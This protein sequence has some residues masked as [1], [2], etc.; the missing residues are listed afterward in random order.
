MWGQ[1]DT[2]KCAIQ[3]S[4]KI[5]GISRK[6]FLGIVN[7]IDYLTHRTNWYTVQMSV[8]ASLLYRGYHI[9]CVKSFYERADVVDR[10]DLGAPLVVRVP[11][12]PVK[13]N[14][15]PLG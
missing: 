5:C 13:V 10:V 12:A 15:D 1:S 3:M 14:R 2:F 11:L 8:K 6:Y 9:L 7:L 4:C